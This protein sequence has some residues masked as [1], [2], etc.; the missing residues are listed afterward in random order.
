MALKIKEISAKFG[1]EGGPLDRL[2]VVVSFEGTNYQT[3]SYINL[4]LN[5]K[6]S[7]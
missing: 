3:Y 1:W 4:A 2:Y 7:R 5:Q 6:H